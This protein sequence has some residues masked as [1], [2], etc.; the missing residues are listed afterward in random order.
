MALAPERQGTEP[1]FRRFGLGWQYRPPEAP[2]VMTFASVSE[3]RGEVRAEIHVQSARTGGHMLRRY[4]NLL[5]SRSL[6]ELAKDLANRDGG[7]GFPWRSILEAVTESIIQALRVGPDVESFGGITDRPPGISWLC[8]GLVMA[9]VPNVW[10]AAASTGKSTFSA[11]LALCHALGQPFLGRPT[12]QGVTLYLDWESTADDLA[13]KL[14]LGSR[15]YGLSR[16]PEGIYR[17]PMRGPASMY[18]AAIANRIDSIGATLVIWDGV[19]AAG[20]PVGQ[21]TSYEAVA[22][23]MEA[24]VMSLPPTTH[25]LLDHVT[26]DDLKE[27]KVPL[28]ARGGTRKVEWARNQWS[29]ILDRDAHL[30]KRHVVGWTHTKINRSDYLEPFGVEIIHRPDELGF[31]L[32][33]E[34]EVEPLKDRMSDWRQLLVIAQEVGRPLT[35]REAARLWKG[36]TEKRSVSLVQHLVNNRT[37]TFTRNADGTF[38]PHWSVKAWET[39]SE[40]VGARRPAAGSAP[41]LM[42][43]PSTDEEW[44][45]PRFDKNGNLIRDDEEEQ[46]DLPF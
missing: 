46:D 15:W 43:V 9:H 2:V 20:G 3:K 44:D 37:Q 22:M 6:D 24:L 1:T 26:G 8:E 29:L 42:L 34:S 5:G 35:N 38:E 7:A 10:L 18:A 4:V 45:D 27:Q 36:D 14:W 39:E 31:A 17:M 41:A 32:L 12:K 23:D 28:K 16:V 19:Q 11:L 40:P 30:S 33:E 21:Y 13:E 25:V